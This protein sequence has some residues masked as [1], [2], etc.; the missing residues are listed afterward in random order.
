[1]AR[2]SVHQLIQDLTHKPEVI[3]AFTANPGPVFADYDLTDEETALLLEATP[4]ALAALGVH[5]ILQM[6]YLILRNP[7]MGALVTIKGYLPQLSPETSQ[8]T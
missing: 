8:E 2:Y 5:P 1:M 7:G 4:Q 6:H 3:A